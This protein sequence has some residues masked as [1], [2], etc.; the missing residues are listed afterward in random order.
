MMSF[1]STH[2]H[3]FSV[4]FSLFLR[5]MVGLLAALSCFAVA[6]VAQAKL[7]P[8]N[9]AKAPA[10]KEDLMAIQ[11]ALME[12]SNHVRK[13]TVS[14]SLGQGFGSGVII[15][16]DGLI[17]TAAHVSG[18]VDK[19]LTVIMNDGTKHKAVS[20]GL[21]STT[22]AAMIR[23]VDEGKYP[24]VEV[25]K[26]NDYKLGHWVF[27]LGHSG[28]FDQ[29]R[30]PV[31]RLGRIVKDSETTLHTDCKVIGGDSGGPLFD[32]SGKLIGIHSRV[33]ET[34]VENMHVPMREYIRHWDSMKSNEFIGDGPFAKRPVK[35][36]GFIG[37]GT[38]DSE[39]GLLVGKVGKDTPAEEAGVQAGDI[40]LSLNGKELADKAA[41]KAILKEM[42]E[43]DKV[44]LKISR[45]GEPL[46][47]E[48][49]LGKR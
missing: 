22:D 34:L 4:D 31:L 28:G 47:I 6:P 30:G 32:M 2:T 33:S 14:I 10:T 19:E 12:S 35:G 3:S 41:F 24:Y 17:L 5:K 13:A 20:M 8:F 1:T 27:A 15:S 45:R 37:L 25:N 36:S 21:N 39:E 46:T 11:N 40:L 48:F 38:S 23:I 44:E 9:E 26:E 29:E 18:G 42:A 43:G 16:P 49:K 7:F